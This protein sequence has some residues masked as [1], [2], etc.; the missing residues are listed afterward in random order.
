MGNTNWNYVIAAVEEMNFAKG[1][2][3]TVYFAA[4]IE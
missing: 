1:R 2:K 4:I 3:A